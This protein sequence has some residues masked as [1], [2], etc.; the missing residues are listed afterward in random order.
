MVSLSGERLNKAI[1]IKNRARGNFSFRMKVQEERLQELL[2]YAMHKV[3][4]FLNN[5]RSN[6]VNPRLLLNEI[7]TVDKKQIIDSYED[8]VSDDINE[9]DCYVTKTSG[10]TGTPFSSIHDIESY[11][12]GL[13]N[14]TFILNENDISE[15]PRILRIAG[16]I[17]QFTDKTKETLPYFSLGLIGINSSLSKFE[18]SIL[19]QIIDFKPNIISGHGSEILL[20]YKIFKTNQ[21]FD[22][23][24]DIKLLICGGESL[25]SQTRNYIKN[26]YKSKVVDTY[27]MQEIGDIAVQCPS[28]ENHYHIYEESVIVEL[29]DE[30]GNLMKKSDNQLGEFVVTG[31]INKYMPLMRYKTGDTGLISS[32]CPCGY[33]GGTIKLL[34]GRKMNPVVLK[35]GDLLNT[36]VLKR[37]LEDLNVICFQLEQ[38]IPGEIDINIVINDEKNKEDLFKYKENLNLELGWKLDIKLNFCNIEDLIGSNGKIKPFL[39]NIETY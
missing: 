36:Y 34:E 2:N 14:L 9:N 15:H 23:L 28:L 29:V 38:S 35:D 6:L 10:S 3:P 1:K 11:Y 19:N 7:S 20:L 32:K 5:S 24:S 33:K 31:L 13:A 37:G 4:K 27:G 39:C 18:T 16:R 12:E 30:Y 8:Y 17:N 22:K 25:S 26:A 21:L